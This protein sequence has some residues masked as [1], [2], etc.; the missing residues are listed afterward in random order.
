[1]NIILITLDACRVDHLGFYGYERNTSPNL[2]KIA[3]ESIVFLNNYSVVPQSDPAIVSI[4]TG[5]YPHNHGIRTLGN[6][7]S[8]SVPALHQL[9][10]SKGY[11]T[12]CMSI[13]QNDN[14]SIKN[15]FDEF[16]LLR[17]R[18]KSKIKRT[19]KKLLD[20]KKQFGTSEIVTDNAI[21][22]IR[23]NSKNKF[24]LYL[25]YMELH[26]PYNPPSP[27]DHIFDPNYD[28]KHNFNDL[29]GG[30]IKR[31]D[32]IFN[33]ILPDEE[34]RHSI[35]HYDGS[36]L[37]LDSQIE[38][39]AEFLKN[40][41]LWDESI[42]IIL[43]DH[44][45]HLGEH[46]FFYQHV[47]SVYQPSLRTPLIIKAPGMHH[48]KI[49]ALTESIDIMPTV[50]DLLGMPLEKPVDGK[51]LT[52][53]ANGSAE[54]IKNLVFAESGVSLFKQNK[55]KYIEGIEGKWRMVTD[56]KWKLIYIP[57]PEEGIYEL[58]N[59]DKDP[60]EKT[61]LAGQEK[62]IEEYL[63]E[64]LY[65]WMENKRAAEAEPQSAPYTGKD[66]EKVKER[67]KRLGYID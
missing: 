27:F 25:H 17:W 24:F 4:L 15:G 44:G 65:L 21:D 58:Y 2:D 52:P 6:A 51:T 56:G 33:K 12:A 50:L 66:E 28:G 20:R 19:L 5:M 37:Y 8:I 29:D 23:K 43:G 55:R 62:E 63:K 3:E 64:K 30:K 39:L 59:I 1:M 49:Y 61:N 10:K 40:E 67:L 18:V 31:G 42:I 47:A 54:K 46:D 53:L 34:I 38:R 14:D 11:K 13:E 26:W 7:K 32:L 22:W 45:E 41:K 48:K 60:M 35:A 36:I 16:N 9:L 57:H